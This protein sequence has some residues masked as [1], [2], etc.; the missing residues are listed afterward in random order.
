MRMIISSLIVL[1]VSTAMAGPTI[2]SQC[3]APKAQL[4]D[5]DLKIVFKAVA[6]CYPECKNKHFSDFTSNMLDSDA[7]N[8]KGCASLEKAFKKS[9]SSLRK[10]YAKQCMSGCLNVIK[11]EVDEGDSIEAQLGEGSF[12]F[13]ASKYVEEQY[14][15]PCPPTED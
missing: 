2:G 13:W 4:V 7:E 5:K 6:G 14:Q 10:W 8:A 9:K 15:K 11:Q 12:G 1:G 3:K